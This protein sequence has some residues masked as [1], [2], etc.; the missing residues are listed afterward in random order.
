LSRI[1]IVSTLTFSEAV[2]KLG[3]EIEA[4]HSGIPWRSIRGLGNVLRH[5][6]DVVDDATIQRIVAEGLA[7]LRQAC[8]SELR[9]LEEGKATS[10]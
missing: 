8:E 1:S 3:P 4:R 2:R 9:R 5:D 6:Y 7:T 10:E